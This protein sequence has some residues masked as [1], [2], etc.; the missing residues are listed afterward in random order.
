VFSFRR[1]NAVEVERR[2]HVARDLAAAC[3]RILASM[4]GLD[5][6]LPAGFSHDLMRT[7]IGS[8]KAAFATA[9]QVFA[10][11]KMF[12]LGWVRVANPKAK[13]AVGEIVAVE[14]R[15][16]GLWTL[17]FSRIVEVVDLPSRFGFIYSTTRFH[18]EM[19]EERFLIEFD[20]EAGGVWYDLEAVSQPAHPAARF[21][22]P[23]SRMYQHKFAR[24]SHRRLSKLIP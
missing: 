17:N 12:D 23:I 22:L 9:K 4:K 16:L 3:P 6:S 11:W 2:L 8:G 18:V 5:S 20:P 14:A 24:D 10:D 15:T 21:G 7:R 19:G 1:P 13:I